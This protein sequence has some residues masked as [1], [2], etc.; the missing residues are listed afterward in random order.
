ML[1]GQLQDPSQGPAG[2]SGSRDVPGAGTAA[3]GSAW[4]WPGTDS[5]T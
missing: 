1:L 3:G 5:G 2:D 4:A